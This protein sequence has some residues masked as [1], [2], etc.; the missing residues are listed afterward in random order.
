[1]TTIAHNCNGCGRLK[2]ETNNWY[3]VQETGVRATLHPALQIRAF[4]DGSSD[5][6][7]YCSDA[8]LGK[9]VAQFSETLR[10]SHQQMEW[11]AAQDAEQDSALDS[12]INTQK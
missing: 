2:G 4:A 7:H 9:R 5:M 3:A 1:M 10:A 11:A 12:F 6:E 8:C